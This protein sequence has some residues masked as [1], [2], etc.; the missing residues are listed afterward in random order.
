MSKRIARIGGSQ[1]PIQRRRLVEFCL[2]GVE[3][4]SFLEEHKSLSGQQSGS[5]VLFDLALGS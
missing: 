4:A 2:F 5:L 3:A 1:E